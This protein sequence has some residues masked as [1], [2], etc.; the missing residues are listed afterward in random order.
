MIPG[1]HD[2]QLDPPYNSIFEGILSFASLEKAEDTLRRLQNLRQRFVAA[3]DKKGMDY[4]RLTALA[5]R[6]RAEMIASNRKVGE[7]KRLE[8]QEIALWF[9]IWLETPELFGDWIALRKSTD[10]YRKL[11]EMQ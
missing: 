8:K 4:C 7:R 10:D 5:G 2:L 11:L 1:K 6:R 9:R 3:G